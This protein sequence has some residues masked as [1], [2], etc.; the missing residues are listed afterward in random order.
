MHIKRDVLKEILNQIPPAPPETGGIIG[1]RDQIVSLFEMDPGIDTVNPGCYTPD[2]V[3]L[4]LT[5]HQW[6]RVGIDFYG[7]V[8]SHMRGQTE[9][10]N[11]D[12]EYIKNIMRSMP[13]EIM[14]L[15]FPIVIDGKEM[16]SFKALKA[17]K[18]IKIK[19]DFIIII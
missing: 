7:I 9:L 14:C 2:T 1:G 8:H 10:S 11:G 15:Y 5:I 12:I 13:A 3:N 17:P 4:N 19:K 18:S 16:Y 6:K